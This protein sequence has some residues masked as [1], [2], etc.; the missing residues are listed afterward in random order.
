[1][2][3]TS[4]PLDLLCAA[5]GLILCFASGS[6]RAG[7]PRTPVS[8]SPTLAFACMTAVG[9]VEYD[10]AAFVTKNP[11]PTYEDHS[12]H[13]VSIQH[14]YEAYLKQ[15]YGYGGFVQCAQYDTLAEIEKWLQWR[16]E[17]QVGRNYQLVTT[18][19]TYSGTVSA[20]EEP[21]P[22]PAAPPAAVSSP[23][24]AYYA[25]SAFT[26]GVAYDNQP[27]AA[28]GDT[29]TSRLVDLSYGIFVAETF[30][31]IGVGRTCT[32]KPSYAEAQSYQQQVAAIRKI[33]RS[34]THWVYSA[35]PK[36]P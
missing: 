19:W 25:C 13:I 23:A 18:D 12:K 4:R 17:Y 11:G 26:K 24:T 31:N 5:L 21:T 8:K 6:A 27:F 2:N 14:A 35:K 15:R 28:S 7:E 29:G 1:M 33:P 34:V 3:A 9:N 22:P 10:S 16:K 32:Q 36:S 30:G 20:A